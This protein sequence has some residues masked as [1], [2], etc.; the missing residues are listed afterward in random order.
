MEIM[1]RGTRLFGFTLVEL[2]V[3][4]SIIGILAAL[5]LPAFQR[6]RDNA[7]IGALQNDIRLYEQEFDTFELDN[8][9]YPPS[10]STPG[11]FPTGMEDRMSPAWKLPSP[12]GGTYRWVYTTEEDPA[13]RVAYID[14]VHSA[15]NP[16]AIDPDRLIDIDETLDDG[17]PS[18]G[19]L[20]LFGENLRF[21]IKL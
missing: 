16:I 1:H 17:N 3:A 2:A 9:F 19:T 21:Y 20:Q 10:V 8:G 4:V 15:A 11:V 12:L 7:R 5:A 13:D 6:S 14:I 18:T